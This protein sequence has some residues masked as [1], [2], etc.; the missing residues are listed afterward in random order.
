MPHLQPSVY[1]EKE[2]G[3]VLGGSEV[4]LGAMPANE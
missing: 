2:M 3:A 4:L 1:L